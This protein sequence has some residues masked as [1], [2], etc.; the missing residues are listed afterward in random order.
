M[1]LF[2]AGLETLKNLAVSHRVCTMCA[3]KEPLNCHRTLLISR[4]L[5]EQNTPVVHILADGSLKPH[6]EVETDL[7]D[8]VGLGEGELFDDPA[9]RLERAYAKRRLAGNYRR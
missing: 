2:Q 3:E 1:E 8:W 6:S 5:A 9:T 7:M 4:A